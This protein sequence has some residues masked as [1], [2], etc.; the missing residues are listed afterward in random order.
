MLRVYYE[1]PAKKW[2]VSD[3]SSLVRNPGVVVSVKLDPKVGVVC[4]NEFDKEILS[5][6]CI[7]VVP[8]IRMFWSLVFEVCILCDVCWEI[9]LLSPGDLYELVIESSICL[10]RHD[11]NSSVFQELV[12]KPNLY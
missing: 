11:G 10:G 1:P 8:S 5:S 12:G 3:D 2:A 9:V 7:K 6:W 4:L